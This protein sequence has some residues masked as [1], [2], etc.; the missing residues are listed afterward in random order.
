MNEGPSFASASYSRGVDENVAS[1]SDV[2]AVIT[3]N[4]PD[5]DTLAYAL[6]GTGSSTFAVSSSGQITTAADINYEAT[7]S[8]SLT[9]TATD[10]GNLTDTATVNITVNNVVEDS[11]LTGLTVPAANVGLTSARFSVTLT[12]PD[13]QNTTVYVRYRTPRTSGS[14]T[15]TSVTTSGTSA[16]VDVTGLTATSDY[17]VQASLDSGFPTSGRQQADF[18]TSANSAPDFGATTATRQVDE[19]VPGG[20]N[21]GLPVTATDSNAG[22]TVTYALSGTDAAFFALGSATGQ[23]TV[24]AGTT[25]DF[26]TKERYTVTITATDS[27]LGTDTIT[28]SIAVQDIDEAG[29]LGSIVFVV[30]S[31]GTDYGYDSGSFGSLTS[32]QFPEGL[33]DDHTART[34]EALYEN[35]DAEWV[36]EYSGGTAND[37]LSDEEARDRITLTVTYADDVDTREFVLGGFVEASGSNNRITLAPPLP[38]RDWNG[39]DGET[40]RLDFHRHR[41]Q[42]ATPVITPV[43]DPG[44]S[45]GSMAAFISETTPGGPVVAQ[46]LIVLLVY[47]IWM[48]KGAQTVKSLMIGGFILVLTPWVPVVFGMGDIVS[49]VINFVNILLGAYVYKYYFES[50][51]QYA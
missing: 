44:A 15:E 4:D 3:A 28:V 50:S 24:G 48:W 37:W 32:G 41:S 42:A 9:L 20:T 18:S 36:L 16:Q 43:V 26:E 19:N 49:A 45:T 8:Y 31:S 25:I 10:P 6:S 22:D 33:F 12:N 30:G 27:H 34:V 39:H 29:L 1:G 11:T 38:S 21:V 7:A 35:A 2:G 13:S 14:W 46:N 5:G 40:V 47:V 17:R 51:E 23:I